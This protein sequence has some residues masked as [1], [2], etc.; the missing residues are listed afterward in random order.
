MMQMA[1]IVFS[2]LMGTI[3]LLMAIACEYVY[4]KLS[5]MPVEAA[6]ILD[7]EEEKHEDDSIFYRYQ[8]QIAN[9]PDRLGQLQG[10]QS[11]LGEIGA[12]ISVIYD[13]A[14]DSYF[15]PKQLWGYRVGTALGFCCG[16]MFWIILYNII[17]HPEQ[18]PD[19]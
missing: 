16:A 8:I 11:P 19:G 13:P 18:M 9:K 4:W 10:I 12:L 2:G 15:T 7:I 3:S 1:F 6:T 14:S 17:E 5:R